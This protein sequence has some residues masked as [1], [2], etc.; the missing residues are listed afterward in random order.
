MLYMIK[1]HIFLSVDS[2][3]T[4]HLSGKFNHHNLIVWGSQNPHQVAEHVQDSVKVNVLCAVSS[5]QVYRSFSFS[6]TAIMGYVYLDMLE[7]FLV[8][9]LNVNSMIWQQ[10]GAHPHYDRD[11]IQYL[12]FPG[13]CI[14]RG[15]YIPWPPRSPNLTPMDFSFWGFVKDM[16]TYH[17]CQWT[18]RSS[19]TV[20][21]MQLI[22]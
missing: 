22:W 8:P 5:T 1:S 2:D 13:R 17:P 10:D 18:F 19:V 3:V 12:T 14:D 20:F 7:H 4:F 15:S 9:R 16:C 6:E 11:V 21:L